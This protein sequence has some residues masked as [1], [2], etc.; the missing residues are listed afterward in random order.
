MIVSASLVGRRGK[1]R[2]GEHYKRI[3]DDISAEFGVSYSAMYWGSS[4]VR[5]LGATQGAQRR[6][7]EETHDTTHRSFHPP[8]ANTLRAMIVCVLFAH[9]LH[10]GVLCSSLFLLSSVATPA[11]CSDEALQVMMS[12][13]LAQRVTFQT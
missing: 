7:G 2:G 4:P 12:Y 11:A 5:A 8:F 9:R 10:G 1:T 3:V 13:R 6:E